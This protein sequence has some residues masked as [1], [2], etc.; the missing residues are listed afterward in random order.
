MT[1]ARFED[2]GFADQPLRLAIQE[3]DDLPV[4]SALIQDAVGLAGEI[5]W[6]PRRRRLAILLNRFRWEDREAAEKQR[7]GFERVRSALVFDSVRAVRTSGLDPAEKDMIYAVLQIS[8]APGEDGAGTVTLDLAGDGML[9]LDVEC[10]D[11]R[12]IDLSRPWLA[13]ASGAPDHELD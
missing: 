13:N 11:G 3:P 5:S 10:L 8:F 6:M 7:R 12:V 9:A 4:V 1:D 2:A